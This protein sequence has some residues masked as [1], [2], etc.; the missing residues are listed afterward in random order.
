M[1]VFVLPQIFRILKQF[2]PFIS[3]NIKKNNNNCY[4][5]MMALL[6]QLVKLINKWE[7]YWNCFTEFKL[8][9]DYGKMLRNVCLN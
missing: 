1:Y 2:G 8:Q 9:K 4:I 7:N 3:I 5:L 6:K